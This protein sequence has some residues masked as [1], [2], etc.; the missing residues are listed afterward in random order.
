MGVQPIAVPQSLASALNTAGDKSN[1]DFGYLVNTAQRESSL[2]P[3]A[4]APSS[5]ATG[6]FQFLDSTWLQ[7]MKEEGPRLGYQKYSDAITQDKNGDY[8]IKDKAIR[9]QVLKLREDPQVASD[10]AAAFTQS[11]GQYL[12]QK[13]G[14][15]PSPGELYIAHFLGPQGAEK[16]FDAGL[17]DP[18]QN[19]A[20]LFPSQARS[21]PTIF[22]ANGHPRTVR[23]VYKALVAQHDGLPA[24]TVPDA[25]P[26]FLAQ[27]MANGMPGSR[28]STDDVPSRLSKADMSFT[29]MFSTQPGGSG[30]QPLIDS[31]AAEPLIDTSTGQNAS[32]LALLP[33]ESSQSLRAID[34]AMSGPSDDDAGAS[35]ADDAA[36]AL[37]FAPL[38][39]PTPLMPPGAP[40]LADPL[41]P[42]DL[43]PPVDLDAAD[44]NGLPQ[45][46]VLMSPGA[47]QANSAF[48]TQLIGQQ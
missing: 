12:Q 46:R 44:P 48:F 22:Y 5:S 42:V 20:R 34:T 36:S 29:Q 1:V 2:N 38:P 30:V 8:V 27:Q 43:A 37:G 26:N 28:W 14:R 47:H 21:N 11:N 9:A 13:F 16:L 35:D 32:P 18:D 33:A 19:A 10:M 7:V 39:A 45:P 24:T 40:P 6:L 31:S 3:A 15:M 41:A 4:K 23:E 17:Q 25:D